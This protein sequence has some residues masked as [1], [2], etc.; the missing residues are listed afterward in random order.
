MCAHTKQSLHAGPSTA[1]R[2]TPALSSQGRAELRC[3]GAALSRAMGVWSLEPFYTSQLF[4]SFTETSFCVLMQ[5]NSLPSLPTPGLCLAVLK[6]YGSLHFGFVSPALVALKF[7]SCG[8]QMLI[9]AVSNLRERV[10][11]LQI[12]KGVSAGSR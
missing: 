11:D 1:S 12:G 4:T 9:P 8:P 7:S 3:C 6:A 2:P 10:S 5:K